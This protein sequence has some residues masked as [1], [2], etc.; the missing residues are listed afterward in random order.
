SMGQ[1]AASYAPEMVAGS[2]LD[3]AATRESGFARPEH[4]TSI[5]G[6]DPAFYLSPEDT[7]QFFKTFADNEQLAEPFDHAAEQLQ[8]RLLVEAA[9]A[10]AEAIAAGEQDPENFGQVAAAFGF[11]TG[12]EYMAQAEVRGNMDEF[13]AKVRGYI[14]GVFNYSLGK[15]PGSGLTWDIMKYVAGKGFQNATA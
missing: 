11:T 12:S 9:E 2:R 10:D 1:I 3:D 8:Q 13:D 7:Y 4:F 14:G 5:P 15:M 6:L